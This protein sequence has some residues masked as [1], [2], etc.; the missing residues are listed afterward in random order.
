MAAL[1]EFPGATLA[2]ASDVSTREADSTETV[3]EVEGTGE[4]TNVAVLSLG[5]VTTVV[6]PSMTIVLVPDTV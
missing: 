3:T 5:A 2:E 1:C 6:V 4:R